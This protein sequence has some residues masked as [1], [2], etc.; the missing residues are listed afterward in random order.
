[1]VFIIK[2]CLDWI[3]ISCLGGGGERSVDWFWSSRCGNFD[4][5]RYIVGVEFRYYFVDR[6]DIVVNGN[7]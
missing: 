4:Y 2:Y 6:V 3:N 7:K 5:S 1:M